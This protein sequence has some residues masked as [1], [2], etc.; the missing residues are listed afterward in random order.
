MSHHFLDIQYYLVKIRG[1]F[2][3]SADRKCTIAAQ[4]VLFILP[5]Y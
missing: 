5:R 4:N 3:R 2:Y 1:K